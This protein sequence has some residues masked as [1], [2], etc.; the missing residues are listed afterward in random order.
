MELDPQKKFE[1]IEKILKYFYDKFGEEDF[2][3]KINYDEQRIRIILGKFGISYSG[4]HFDSDVLLKTEDKKI[5]D[6]SEY[7]LN[8]KGLA[9][10]FHD[11]Y[12]IEILN[13]EEKFFNLNLYLNEC[14]E[15]IK[16]NRKIATAMLLRCCVEILVDMNGIKERTLAGSID[17]FAQSMKDNP[18]FIIFSKY[19]KENELKKFLEGVKNFGN[20]AA[21]LN[22]QNV[23]D[24]IEKYDNKEILKLFC[25]LIENSILRE[26]IN[27]RNEQDIENKIKSIDFAIKEKMKENKIEEE[28]NDEIPF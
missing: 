9:H 15:C 7:L 4:K 17:K 28:V 27:N 2:Y 19:N 22:G 12:A 8:D 21:H 26:D 25:I 11:K 14:F 16:S 23:K 6:L 3:G 20:D 1:I 10:L 24:F 13:S 5:Y 18:K